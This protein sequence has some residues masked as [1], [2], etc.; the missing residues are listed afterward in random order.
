MSPAAATIT[1]SRIRVS[2]RRHHIQQ[3]DSTHLFTH[4]NQRET[5]VSDENRCERNHPRIPYQ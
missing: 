2:V 5:M 3:G 1:A 4:L